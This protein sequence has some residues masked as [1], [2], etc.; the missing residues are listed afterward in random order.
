[1]NKK[2]LNLFVVLSIVI[3]SLAASVSVYAKTYD[4]G[5]RT[6]YVHQKKTAHIGNFPNSTFTWKSSNERVASVSR[7]GVIKGRKKGTAYITAQKNGDT[8]LFKVK[9]KYYK[10]KLAI[11]QLYPDVLL[12][13]Q[14][15]VESLS[16]KMH[17]SITRVLSLK[18]LDVDK[19]DGLIIPGGDDV[20]PALYGARNISSYNINHKLDV[21]MLKSIKKFRKAGKPIFGICAGMQLLNIAYG[22]TLKQDIGLVQGRYH[23]GVW[24]T[25]VVSNGSL[26]AK[27]GAELYVKHYHH[28]AVKKLG[29]GLKITMRDKK[30]G[31][32]EAVEGIRDPVYGLQW[33][34]DLM[35]SKG[36]KY[37]KIFIRKCRDMAFANMNKGL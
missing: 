12:N 25:V 21:F 8:Y 17:C 15:M 30:D 33:H 36:K 4:Y 31:E 2:L 23:Y 7:T 18:D 22:G 1:M 3:M 37:F 16:R 24:R 11:V 10:T 34:P 6:I 9:V 26:F 14:N 13:E 5:E 29:S 32:V 35:G 20:D 28:Q 19:Y 27:N